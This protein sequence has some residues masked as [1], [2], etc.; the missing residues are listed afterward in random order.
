MR[1]DWLKRITVE[2]EKPA[3]R[4]EEGEDTIY[5]RQTMY[6]GDRN[7]RREDVPLPS[8]EDSPLSNRNSN[9][10]TP[11]SIRRGNVALEGIQEWDLTEDLSLSSMMIASTPAIARNTTLDDI[12]QREIESLKD[13][14]VTTSRLDMI[15][16]TS[17]EETL[18]RS[19]SRASVTSQTNG[20]ATSEQTTRE[21]PSP[22]IK[23][24]KRTDSVK[25]KGKSPVFGGDGGEAIPNSPIV[26]YKSSQTVGVI[27]RGIQANAQTSPKRP[28][29]K[30]EDSHDLLRRLAR[31]SSAS[32]SPGR[33]TAPHPQPVQ[34]QQENSAPTNM[35]K[36]DTVN[37]IDAPLQQQNNAEEVQSPKTIEA[38]REHPQMESK[39]IPEE[40]SSNAEQ[41]PERSEPAQNLTP[42]ASQEDVDVTPMPVDSAPTSAKTPI[43][44]GA[45]IDTPGPLTSRRTF[46][47]SSTAA[48]TSPL[49]SP[50][51]GSPSKRSPQ[52][53]LPEQPVEVPQPEPERREPSLPSSAL[54]AIVDAA[55]SKRRSEDNDD[56]YGESTIDSLEDMMAPDGEDN[57]PAVEAEVDDDTLQGLQLPAEAPKTEAERKRQEEILHLHNMNSRL[58]KARTGLRD[59]SRGIK[60][61][62]HQVDSAEIG[63]K[64]S[65][66]ACTRCGCVAGGNRG[67]TLS[68]VWRGLNGLIFDENSGRWLKLTW[69][70]LSLLIF[71]SWL[72]TETTLCN[73]YCH[74][75][76]ATHMVGF[77]VDPDAP[78]LPFVTVTLLGRP[79]RWLWRPI[80]SALVW[81]W[82]CIYHVFTVDEIKRKAATR[83]AKAFT[84]R[85][86]VGEAMESELSML[87]DEYL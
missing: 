84:A 63:N 43:V 30:R 42:L 20:V 27:D 58:R 54:A 85:T 15:R 9:Q 31:V 80:L 14:A 71:F 79:L 23:L 77:G 13:R 74:P 8:I 3:Q 34:T 83:T 37:A 51:K 68:S 12:R 72:F 40:Q 38:V 78:R 61:V 35:E 33:I 82:K 21:P 86:F 7:L 52:K 39:K 1:K 4:E 46:F 44:T 22:E 36:G 57:T 53:K 6:T 73:Y 25:S 26:V 50:T 69:L 48:R 49:R 32:P 16:E 29:H 64:T 81:I 41:Q 66:E 70:G 11:Y 87:D 65:T 28:A 5:R 55:K 75:T 60:R 24:R 17:P 45:W 47:S 19:S 56:I 76:Y 2:E 18:Q 62:E 67:Y 10:G 59:A